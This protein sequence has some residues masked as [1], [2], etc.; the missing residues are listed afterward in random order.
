VP[1]IV[2][3]QGGQATWRYDQIFFIELTE[4]VINFV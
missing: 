3:E 4:G 2:H 1:T